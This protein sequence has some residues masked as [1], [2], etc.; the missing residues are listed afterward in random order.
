MTFLRVWDLQILWSRQHHPIILQAV[1]EIIAQHDLLQCKSN[2][3]IN[4]GLRC[5]VCFCECA[6]P[7]I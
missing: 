7:K 2:R 1:I 4:L 6:K 3:G 5:L